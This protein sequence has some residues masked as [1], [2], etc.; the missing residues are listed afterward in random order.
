MAE[1]DIMTL[2]MSIQA[3]NAEIKKY[4]SLL[5]SETLRDPDEIQSLILSYEKAANVLKD[6]YMQE[7]K[8]GSNLPEYSELVN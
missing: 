3:V 8:E 4:E 5:T 1:V 6:A 2:M 7:W